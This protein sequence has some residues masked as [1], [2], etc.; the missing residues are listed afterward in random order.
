MLTVFPMSAKQ[1]FF[2]RFWSLIQGGM[3]ALIFLFSWKRRPEVKIN[4]AHFGGIQQILNLECSFWRLF[5]DVKW[6]NLNFFEKI[7]IFR[8]SEIFWKGKLL[9]VRGLF[10]RS[11]S[12]K[13]TWWTAISPISKIYIFFENS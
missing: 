9:C 11:N 2:K 3:S 13:C 7:S 10:S 6:R 12:L 1:L 5:F 4:F 8:V